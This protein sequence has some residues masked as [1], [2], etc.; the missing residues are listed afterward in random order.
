[1]KNTIAV[2]FLFLLPYLA[3]G[4]QSASAVE[5]LEHRWMQALTTQDT[6]FLQKYYHPRLVY[7]HSSGIVDDKTTWMN[8]FKK[9]TLKY[10]KLE[11]QSMRVDL[12]PKMA[13]ATYGASF[14]VLNN[15]SPLDFDARVIHVYVHEKEGWKLVAHQTTRLA[16]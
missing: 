3:Q 10:L 11:P 9:G 7:T 1:M 5:A 8:N 15:G 4:Q 13:I 14:S 2:F 16:K 12:Y 6:I